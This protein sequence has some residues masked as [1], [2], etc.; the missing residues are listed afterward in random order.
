MSTYMKSV[1]CLLAVFIL[2]I[3]P[4]TTLSINFGDLLKEAAKVI[5]PEQG[6]TG[7]EIVSGLKEALEIGTKNAVETVGQLDGYYKDPEIRIPLPE[8][9]QQAEKILRAA[10]YG[11]KVDAFELSMNRAAET[12]APEAKSLFWDAV[13]AMTFDDAK[14]IL[15]GADDEATKYFREKTEGRLSELFKPIVHDSMGQVGVTRYFQDLNATLQT[16]PF[17]NT[18]SFDLDEYVTGQGLDG[19]FLMLARE[20]AK[21]RQ[22]PDARVTDLLQKVFGA[23]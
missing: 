5:Q 13:Q 21:I 7:N 9:V 2:A 19:L 8:S 14:R 23:D 22:N 6:L 10:G 4:T 11:E 18:V 3:S 1:S 15:K 20:E 16:I 12:A 17:A